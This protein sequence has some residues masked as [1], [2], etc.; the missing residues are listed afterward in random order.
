MSSEFFECPA[1]VGCCCLDEKDEKEKLYFTHS[2]WCKNYRH[3]GL[4]A[5]KDA[6]YHYSV[7]V[8]EKPVWYSTCNVPFA[9]DEMNVKVL[10]L[11][12]FFDLNCYCGPGKR[13]CSLC[14]DISHSQQLL[15]H[16]DQIL[17]LYFIRK[18]DSFI[19]WDKLPL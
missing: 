11:C 17:D 1:R 5:N 15:V 9:N 8:S 16:D 14:G 13:M 3:A 4:V 19:D 7:D 2:V 10:K 12:K 6:V 18:L